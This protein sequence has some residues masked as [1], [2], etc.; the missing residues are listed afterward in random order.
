MSLIGGCRF[1]FSLYEKKG[2]VVLFSNN[3]PRL[4]PSNNRP[5]FCGLMLAYS[6]TVPDSPVYQFPCP[7]ALG[8]IIGI[9]LGNRYRPGCILLSVS[10]F[11]RPTCPYSTLHM[12]T[13]GGRK[14]CFEIQ[15]EQHAG[16]CFLKMDFLKVEQERRLTRG[17]VA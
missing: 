12:G 16:D 5:D 7:N 1:A 15:G 2:V 3:F 11:L 14:A 9:L 17:G 4:Q 10:W 8:Q 13:V 6:D